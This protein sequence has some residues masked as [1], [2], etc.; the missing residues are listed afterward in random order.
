MF[1]TLLGKIFAAVVRHCA[2]ALALFLIAGGYIPASEQNDLIGSII[3]LGG[4]AW[5]IYDKKV[6]HAKQ[7]QMK[8]PSQ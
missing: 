8:G 7:Q 1:N 3:F 5:S 6:S 4:V 2:G